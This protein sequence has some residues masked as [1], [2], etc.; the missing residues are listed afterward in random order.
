MPWAGLRARPSLP[1]GRRQRYTRGLGPGNLRQVD[2]VLSSPPQTLTRAPLP[3]PRPVR[4]ILLESSRR[5]A[6]SL[7]QKPADAILERKSRVIVSTIALVQGFDVADPQP[8]RK[9]PIRQALDLLNSMVDRMNEVGLTA[10]T[11]RLIRFISKEFGLPSPDVMSKSLSLFKMAAEQEA[12][13]NRLAF[14]TPDD[15]IVTEVPGIRE[16]F[17]TAEK[18]G[19]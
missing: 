8:P 2:R 13:G 18:T 6:C 14:L 15:E 7:T 5:S 11:I 3:N 17:G 4:G 1:S 19:G 9:T 10:E 16:P 12:K